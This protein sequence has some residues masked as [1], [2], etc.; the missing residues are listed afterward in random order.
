[1][2]GDSELTPDEKRA[3]VAY[4]QEIKTDRDPGGWGLGRYGPVPE[5]LVIFLIGIVGIVFATVWIAGKS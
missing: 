2:F 3:I 1:V 5:A 4:I